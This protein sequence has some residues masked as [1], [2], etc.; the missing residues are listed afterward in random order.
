MRGHDACMHTLFFFGRCMKT[1]SC[2]PVLFP[3]EVCCFLQPRKII[4]YP[5][6][7]LLI[8][9]ALAHKPSLKRGHQAPA[10]ACSL[11]NC[12]NG[13]KFAWLQPFGASV[14]SWQQQGVWPFVALYIINAIYTLGV[15]EVEAGDMIMMGMFSIVYSVPA[16]SSWKKN[17]CHKPQMTW[18][19]MHGY[20]YFSKWWRPK[21]CLY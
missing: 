12:C 3:W 20:G 5:I 14:S 4:L 21:N 15:P 17:S 18:N 2:T 6:D 19:N 1:H 9:S 10:A 8:T 11:R 16:F 13:S 7:H